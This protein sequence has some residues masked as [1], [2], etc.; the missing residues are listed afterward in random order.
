MN[1]CEE[2]ASG[3]EYGEGKILLLWFCDHV[4]RCLKI[5]DSVSDDMV[6]RGE[7]C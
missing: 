3:V 1:A 6:L 5:L 7:H 4:G 2:Q